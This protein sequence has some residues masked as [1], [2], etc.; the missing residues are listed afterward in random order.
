MS[1]PHRAKNFYFLCRNGG[2][3][4]TIISVFH[5]VVMWHLDVKAKM[6]EL[7]EFQDKNSSAVLKIHHKSY[8][9]LS[10]VGLSAVRNKSPILTD[11]RAL[12]SDVY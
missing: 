3:R 9:P 2:H 7:R 1:T 4:G 11:F 6:K 10:A 5:V 12:R 8:E